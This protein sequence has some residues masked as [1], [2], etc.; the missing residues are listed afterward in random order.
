MFKQ[1]LSAAISILV[2]NQAFAQGAGTDSTEGLLGLEEIIVTAQRRAQ[3]L[4]DTAISLEVVDDESLANVGVTEVNELTKLVPGLQIGRSGPSPQVY[5]RGVGD[6]G[7]TSINNP[8][9]PFYVD[10]VY[11]A[12]SASASGEL[13][14]VERVEVLKGPQGTLYGRNASGGAINIITKRPVLGEYNGNASIEVGGYD[15]RDF[16]DNLV[17]TGALNVPFGDNTAARIAVNVVDKG[18]FVAQDLGDQESVTARVRLLH[19]PNDQLNMLFNAS[20]TDVGGTGPGNVLTNEQFRGDFVPITEGEGRQF[21]RDTA[22][23]TGETAFLLTTPTEEGAFQDLV[24]YNLSAEINYDFGPATLTV[25]PAYRSAE[26][27]WNIPTFFQYFNGVALSTAN[28]FG[29]PTTEVVGEDPETSEA[30]SLEVRLGG[31]TERLNWV[32]GGFYYTE[33][34]Y[35]QFSAFQGIAQSSFNQFDLSTDSFAFFGQTTLALMDNLRLILG[36][37]Y[38]EDKREMD[39]RSGNVATSFGCDFGGVNVGETLCIGDLYS[40]DE[41]FDDFSWKFGF[42]ADVLDDSLLYATVT[43]GFKAGGFNTQSVNGTSTEV[44]DALQFDPEILTSYEIGLKNNLLD[45]RLQLNVEAF[46]WDYK[47]HQEPTIT[48]SAAGSINLSYLNAGAAEIYGL[49]L[50]SVAKLWDGARVTAGVEVLETEYTEFTIEVPEERYIGQSQCTPTPIADGAF[51]LDCSGYDVSRAPDVT[52]N[53]AFSQ[54]FNLGDALIVGNANLSYASERYT[55]V[56]FN[57]AQLE[58]SYSL[59]DLSATYYHPGDVWNLSVF[60]RNVTNEQVLSNVSNSN[61]NAA[62]V[63]VAQPS[64]SYGLRLSLEF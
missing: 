25:V 34:Q 21:A 17:A 45:G 35:Q 40:G 36:A 32:V 50:T 64:R 46:Y 41:T 53:A 2:A 38:T 52:F 8:A 19:E 55:A 26:Q 33:D 24:F 39:G 31:E 42:E 22:P 29:A 43:R 9:V 18:G 51:S 11:V 44:G 60:A 23:F 15:G 63:G 27:T 56:Q 47:D 57:D 49:A 28:P 59:L 10:G 20:Y 6:F 14:D 3:S 58:D 4:Q 16:G 7:S 62:T 61:F 5:L 1:A 37:R 48:Q 30:T 12:R 54:E 13:F